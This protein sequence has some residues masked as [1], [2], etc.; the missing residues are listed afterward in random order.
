MKLAAI[1]AI[2][3]VAVG[4]VVWAQGTGS[5]GQQPPT[6]PGNHKPPQNRPTRPSNPKPPQHRPTRPANRPDQN[7][8][9]WDQG[10]NTIRVTLTSDGNR[11]SERQINNSGVR[12][13]R[14]LSDR[15]CNQGRDW[16][17]DSRRIWVDNGCR[18][19]F[20][21]RPRSG[22]SGWGPSGIFDQAGGGGHRPVPSGSHRTV[23][24]ESSNDRQRQTWVGQNRTV[25]LNRRLSNNPCIEGR[26]WGYRNGYIWVDN[27]CRAEFR[28]YPR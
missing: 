24:V 20:E 16:G 18:A 1:I 26:S 21:V 4:G 19:E 13:V 10:A 28:V 5:S 7:H 17:Y 25:R 3:T 12:L 22:N 15:A 23:R 14:R 8:G 2:S 9:N 11:R 27:G 6:R